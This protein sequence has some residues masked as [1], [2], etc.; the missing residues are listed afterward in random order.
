MGLMTKPATNDVGDGGGIEQRE[1]S[2][3]PQLSR[4]KREYH[5]SS[6]YPS[7]E[8]IVLIDERELES[9]DEVQTHKAKSQWIK[10]MQE[11]N[12]RLKLMSLW[13]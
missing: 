8:F 9:F 7:L 12:M 10:V 1:Q 3:T 6:R 13:N 11:M 2:P 4:S 5:P